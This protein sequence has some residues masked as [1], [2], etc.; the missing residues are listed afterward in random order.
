MGEDGARGKNWLRAR[1]HHL[2]LTEL[3]TEFFCFFFLP[4]Q[5]QISRSVKDLRLFRKGKT[6]I[7]VWLGLVFCSH[8]KEGKTLPYS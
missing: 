8:F 7:M 6:S 3:K 5:S 1:G 4:K 2:C